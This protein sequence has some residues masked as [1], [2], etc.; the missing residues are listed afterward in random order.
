MIQSFNS[1]PI[2]IQ[3]SRA[4]TRCSETHEIKISTE[5]MQVWNTS[6]VHSLKREHGLP[7]M[8]PGLPF[9]DTYLQCSS[10]KR[11]LQYTESMAAQNINPGHIAAFHSPTGVATGDVLT[12]STKCIEATTIGSCRSSKNL[13][14]NNPMRKCS[15]GESPMQGL[16]LNKTSRRWPSASTYVETLT[17]RNE[18]SFFGSDWYL[19][20][21]V[22][23]L[24]PALTSLSWN[25]LYKEHMTLGA[26]WPCLINV[27]RNSWSG[28]MPLTNNIELW[29]D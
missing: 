26:N 29:H 9:T 4:V 18:L 2:Y 28:D 8:T 7:R 15:P 25:T 17:A 10:W 19:L 13:R 12:P 16:G 3:L 21:P 6:P 11:Q 24:V 22:K 14:W 27:Q 5:K 1:K 23:F 20:R